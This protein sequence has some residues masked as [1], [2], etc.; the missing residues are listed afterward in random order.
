MKFGGS[1][2]NTQ[3]VRLNGAAVPHKGGS[4]APQADHPQGQTGYREW[5]LQTIQPGIPGSGLA[6]VAGDSKFL[7]MAY[8][9]SPQALAQMTGG[10]ISAGYVC[11]L[12]DSKGKTGFMVGVLNHSGNGMYQLFFQSPVPLTPYARVLVSL[13]NL[14]KAGQVPKGRILLSGSTSGSPLIWF[15]PMGKVAKSAGSALGKA[16]GGLIKRKPTALSE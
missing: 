9:P 12:A 4:A 11:Y 5:R 14:Q 6:V 13:E 2:R 16:I 1:M 15:K 3:S 10:N 7:L 8:L